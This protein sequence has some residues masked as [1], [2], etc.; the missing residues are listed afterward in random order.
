MAPRSTE[1]PKEELTAAEAVARRLRAEALDLD[2]CAREPIHTPGSVQPHAVLLVAETGEGRVLGCSE[3]VGPLLGVEPAAVLGQPRAHWLPAALEA[4]LAGP[5]PEAKLRV[6]WGPNRRMLLATAHRR[7]DRWLIE[8]EPLDEEAQGPGLDEVAHALTQLRSA[9][10]LEAATVTAAEQTRA[11]TGFQRVLIY[12]FDRDWNGEAVAEARDPEAYGSLLGLHFPASDIPAQARAMY[13]SAPA[14][15]VFDRDYVPS[16]ILA[17]PALGNEAIDLSHVRARSL[18]PIHLE[19]QRNL[20]V[21][22]SMSAS[23][24]VDGRLWGLV[25]GHHREPHRPSPDARTAAATVAEALGLRIGKLELEGAWSVREAHA[26]AETSL[27]ERMAERDDLR[28]ALLGGRTTLADLFGAAGAAVVD[29]ESVSTVGRTPPEDAVLAIVRWLSERGEVF[30]TDT[31]SSQHAAADEWRDTGSGLLAA[32]TGPEK[33]RALL[34]FRPEQVATVEWGGDPRKPLEA[35]AAAVLPRRSFERWAEERRGVAAPWADWQPEA[36]VRLARAV[37]GVAL[38]QGRGMAALQAKNTALGEALSR[39]EQLL[40]DKDLLTRE[41][42]HRVKNSLQLVAA[43]VRMQGR[44]ASDPATRAQYDETYARVMSVAR[45]HDSLWRSDEV[46]EVDV[47]QTLTRLCADLQAM[48]G[49]ERLVSVEAEPGLKLPYREASALSLIAV[50]L[51]TN[52]LKYAYAP[53]EPGG[54]EVEVGR[55]PGGRVRL[56]V[57]DQGRGLPP[58]WRDGAR[59]SGL[60]MKLVRSLLSQ[61]GGELSVESGPGTRLMVL[62]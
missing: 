28:E 18:S 51:V 34:W 58:D 25:I 20:G 10:S 27:L 56:E 44:S 38:R 8:L 42:D 45:V 11:L 46:G 5:G 19:Y 14:R 47:G 4:V 52:A 40:A 60:G 41:M 35:T 48:A 17:D 54:V 61:L 62:A 39:S 23:I 31:L 6:A 29:G 50:E 13:L 3:N 1:L 21:N 57:A 7:Q 16:R 59:E 55:A 2:L 15:F 37:E 12:R 22:G 43:F 36:A 33:R 26:S 9:S 53:G 49:A 32:F 30:V 24:L